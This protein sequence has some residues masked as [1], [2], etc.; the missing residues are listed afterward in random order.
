[1]THL[2]MQLDSRQSQILTPRLQYAVR[3]LQLS[4][5][6]YEQE[7]H[8][9][10]EKNPF[11]ELLDA[12]VEQD[13][14]EQS[15]PHSG[16]TTNAPNGDLPDGGAAPEAVGE[17][18]Y[19]TA[20]E[21]QESWLQASSGAHNGSHDGQPSG[22]EETLVANI[23]L[24]QHLRSQSN[25]L[26][27]SERD[28]A[29]VCAV[30]ESLDDDG[31]L[32]L[33]LT[34]IAEMVGLHPSPDACEMST[35]LKLVQSFE[36]VGVG[37]RNVAECLLLQIEDTDSACRDLLRTVVTDHLDRLVKRDVAGLARLLDRPVAEVEGVCNRVRH[38]DPRPGLR[39]GGSDV[40]FIKPDVVARKSRGQWTVQLNPE[41]VPRLQLNH[42]YAK[43]FQQHREAKHAELG[44]YLQEARW[45][46]KNAE[47]RFMTILA[48]AQAIVVRQYGFFE[49]GTLAMKPLALAD[50]AQDVGV[51]ESTV[52]RVTNNKYMAT[53]GG[54]IELK[55]FF[56]RPMQTSGGGTCSA[57]AIR[58]LVQE[59]IAAESP[60]KPLSDVQ[61]TQRL[62]RQGLTVARRTVTKYRQMLKIPS[63]E[64]RRSYPAALTPSLA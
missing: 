18:G 9:L 5:L 23:G 61:I 45:S 3:L 55:H 54:L 6:D 35:A 38:L 17:V 24:R 47:Q 41:I 60:I 62:I 32:R 44:A 39:Y 4:N 16:D 52:C 63:V 7:L 64:Q 19:D 50:I 51:H 30:I 2:S 29:L 8:E 56:S 15:F 21:L 11:L 13:S 22:L 26:P 12:P 46:I 36:P 31:Y 58:R 53:P 10:V 33:G 59:I 14:S 40:Q 48:V 20:G 43:L 28:R 37:A 27:L 42:A 49:Y 34:D 25:L 57:T 1:M